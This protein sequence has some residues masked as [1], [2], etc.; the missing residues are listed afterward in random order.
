MKKE[1]IFLRF[2]VYYAVFLAAYGCFPIGTPLY[3]RQSISGYEDMATNIRDLINIDGY[4]VHAEPEQT[5]SSYTYFMFFEDGMVNMRVH[6]YN[7]FPLSNTTEN[8][9][10]YIHQILSDENG[11]Q[12]KWFYNSLGWGRYTITNDTIKINYHSGWGYPNC[13][14][15]EMWFKVIDRNHIVD[16][17]FASITKTTPQTIDAQKQKY[18][19]DDAIPSRFVPLEKTPYPDSWIKKKKWFW[20]NEQDWKAYMEKIEQKKIKKR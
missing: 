14:A 4:F 3:I 12:A 2:T 1:L 19:Y 7:V 10:Q 9:P 11:K 6:D 20:R 8:I 13:Y 17:Y 15:F 18:I 5:D 16:I